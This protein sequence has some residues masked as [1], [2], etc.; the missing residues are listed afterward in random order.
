MVVVKGVDGVTW[1]RGLGL[2]GFL[3]GERIPCALPDG[4]DFWQQNHT[5][6][7]VVG[8]GVLGS[9]SGNE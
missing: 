5:K 2:P 7:K 1:D 4:T 3:P 9:G 8:H 6:H